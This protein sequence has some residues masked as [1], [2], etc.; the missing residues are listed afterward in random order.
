VFGRSLVYQPVFLRIIS[1]RFDGLVI[2][3]E[4]KYIVNIALLLIFRLWRKP[5]LFWGFGPTYDRLGDRRG[6]LG[7]ALSRWVGSV[8]RSLIAGASGFLAY[9]DSGAEYVADSGMLRARIA[10]VYNTIDIA[11]EYAAY[12]RA[13]SLDRTALRHGFGL[14][15]DA[16]VF[17]FIGRL[18]PLKR[19]H[20]LIGAVETLLAEMK[21][22]IEV[23][24]VG[25]GPE[26][27]SLR[28][29]AGNMA[30]CRFLGP[31]DA[32]DRLGEI[33]RVSEAVVIPGYVGLAVNHAFAHGVPLITCRSDMHSPEI[34]YV[35]D[36]YN[37]LILDGKEG[38]REG[39]RQFV[40]SAEMR[41]RLALGA[42]E[43][44]ASLDIAR[45]VENFDTAV[46][47]ALACEAASAGS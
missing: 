25:G 16:I 5:V 26:E 31:V 38:L 40:L 20:W 24:I 30:W 42:L 12:D 19:V 44:R 37:G 9:T 23:L 15:A 27:A 43:T 21:Q 10:V 47:R 6:R 39:L 46:V 7:R 8:K 17:L 1:G 14:S 36:N 32:P 34:D 33:F 13:Q 28:E 45:M 22:R 4:V 18:T 35:R 3:H 2:G 41:G 29:V 11:G